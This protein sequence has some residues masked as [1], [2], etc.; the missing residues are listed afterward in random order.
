MQTLPAKLAYRSLFKSWWYIDIHIC[1][2]GQALVRI[3]MHFKL[4]LPS[5]IQIKAVHMANL[6]QIASGT[7]LLCGC[8]AHHHSWTLP[9]TSH[10]WKFPLVLVPLGKGVKETCPH[11]SCGKVWFFHFP[12]LETPQEKSQVMTSAPSQQVKQSCVLFLCESSN[13]FISENIF[14]LVTSK[15][16]TRTGFLVRFTFLSFRGYGL[17]LQELLSAPHVSLPGW[18]ADLLLGLAWQGLLAL[19]VHREGE[20]WANGQGEVEDH[21]LAGQRLAEGQAL[22]CQGGVISH[23]ILI[24]EIGS[25]ETKT[26]I[27]RLNCVKFGL[28]S[29][30]MASPA[31]RMYASPRHCD[32]FQDCPKRNNCLHEANVP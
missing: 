11:H 14:T 4:V 3:W 5:S 15:S 9:H 24:S 7:Q 2:V 25:T 23:F 20:G 21:A 6:A 19:G 32:R 8:Q 27:F 31:F 22:C 10:I 12:W 28:K 16:G 18:R 13:L 17:L 1:L 29:K 30:K 26:C